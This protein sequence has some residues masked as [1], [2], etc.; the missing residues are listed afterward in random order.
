MAVHVHADKE[1]PLMKQKHNSFPGPRHF[2]MCSFMML[3]RPI[4][5]SNCDFFLFKKYT[6]PNLQQFA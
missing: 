1:G 5:E 3:F 2:L 6:I 4:T